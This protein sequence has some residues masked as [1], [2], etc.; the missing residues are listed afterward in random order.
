MMTNLMQIIFIARMMLSEL[1]FTSFIKCADIAI[2]P[3]VPHKTLLNWM[4]PLLLQRISLNFLVHRFYRNDE[5]PWL[6][7]ADINGEFSQS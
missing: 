1:W 5:G 7:T 6:S 3:V 2:F 4:F